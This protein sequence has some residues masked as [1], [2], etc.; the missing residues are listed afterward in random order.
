MIRTSPYTFCGYNSF[1]FVCTKCGKEIEVS[2]LDLISEMRKAESS[3][4]KA[5][6]LGEK[7]IK[8]SYLTI[9]RYNNIS[10]GYY[11]PAATLV[12][13]KYLKRGIN[14]KEIDCEH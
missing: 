14:L 3:Y 2:E 12:L 6:A 8:S 10:M 7:P 9:D 5:I 13:E 1:Q 11:S 4:N